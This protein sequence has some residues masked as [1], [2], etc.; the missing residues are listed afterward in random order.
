MDM[1]FKHFHFGNT[2]RYSTQSHLYN[3]AWC[4]TEVRHWQPALL[5]ISE[6]ATSAL[7]GET[8]KFLVLRIPNL[9]V[10]TLGDVWTCFMRSKLQ[11]NCEASLTRPVEKVHLPLRVTVF[12][13]HAICTMELGNPHIP[14]YAGLNFFQLLPEFCEVSMTAYLCVK[15]C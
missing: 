4:C 12:L 11:R 2:L 8:L 1:L 15:W 5:S 13:P 9:L 14:S 6:L 7:S 10:H 3:P